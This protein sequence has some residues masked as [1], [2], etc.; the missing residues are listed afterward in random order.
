MAITIVPPWIA[1]P[2]LIPAPRGGHNDHLCFRWENET[3]RGSVPFW[4]FPN[5]WKQS[6]DWKPGPGLASTGSGSEGAAGCQYSFIGTWPPPFATDCGSLL[7]KG[8]AASDSLPPA[9]T[10]LDSQALQGTLC[11]ALARGQRYGRTGRSGGCS[12][13][14]SRQWRGAGGEGGGEEGSGWGCGG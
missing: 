6:W 1:S 4:K 3:L 13:V 9:G 2:A 11:G 10:D 5:C 8:V 14:G 12:G 7:R